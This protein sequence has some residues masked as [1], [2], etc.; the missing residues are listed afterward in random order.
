[1]MLAGMLSAKAQ[2][3]IVIHGQWMNPPAKNKGIGV[4]EVR[5]GTC[6]PLVTK[7]LSND[8]HFSI[9]FL[10]EHEGFYVV[11]HEPNSHTFRNVF[12]FKPGD[13]L[14]FQMERDTIT[15]IPR[16]ILIGRD[17]K[18]IYSKAPRP[19]SDEFRTVLD[20]TLK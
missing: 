16:F 6:V 7:P 10:P 12:Y 18:V 20:Q 14:S 9:S 3:P 11:A 19:S 15:G 17:G 4:Y 5:Y 2:Q 8:G 13:Q 1:M